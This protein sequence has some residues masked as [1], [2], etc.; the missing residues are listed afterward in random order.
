MKVGILTFHFAVNYGAVLQACA[1]CTML[2]QLGHVPVLIDYR[3]TGS[4]YSHY[5]RW[6]TSRGG[7]NAQNLLKLRLNPKFA[8][9]RRRELP[10]DSHVVDSPE[11]LAT[12]ARTFDALIYG[13]DQ[14]WNPSIFGGCLD[15]GYWAVGVPDSVRRIALSASFGGDL[16]S[17]LPHQSEINRLANNFDV[18]SVREKDA[19]EV[20]DSLPRRQVVQLADPVFGMESW[21]SLL[22]PVKLRNNF[23]FE[24]AIQ[25]RNS[26]SQTAQTI[27]RALGMVPISGNARIRLKRHDPKS[28]AL[29]VGQWLWMVKN[30]K[31]LVTNSF[32]A[33]VFAIL[34]NTPF[35]FVPLE[36]KGN[37]PNP[38]NNRIFD[39]LEWTGLQSRVWNQEWNCDMLGLL[40]MRSGS[41]SMA[42][43]AVQ[44][45]RAELRDFLEA[46][47]V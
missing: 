44:E 42:N 38:R 47:L 16:Q 19:L 5:H 27:S 7:L 18:I 29:S 41:F 10:V 43:A 11:K 39:L 20:F 32:H 30:S 40:E 31:M 8:S 9:F 15:P 33:T 36:G 25:P 28:L 46:Q 21:G 35:V 12:H 6:D 24:F 4:M 23:V 1:T 45:K 2:K 26:F 22:Q 37:Q 34:F 17:V 13:S 3:P 14:I